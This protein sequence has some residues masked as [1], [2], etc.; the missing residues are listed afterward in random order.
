MMNLMTFREIYPGFAGLSDAAVQ[1][2]L[3]NAIC[4]Y[5]DAEYGKFAERMQGLATAHTLVL[6]WYQQIQLQGAKAESNCEMPDLSK[7]FTGSDK[8]PFTLNATVYGRQIQDLQA[9]IN[10][11]IIACV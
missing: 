1:Y 8:A 7:L 3:D 4:D 5:S 2:H 10:G 9:C 11:P 6:N